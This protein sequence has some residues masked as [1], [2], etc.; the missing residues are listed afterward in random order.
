MEVAIEEEAVGEED[1][2]YEAIAVEMEEE[3]VATFAVFAPT[4]SAMARR[5]KSTDASPVERS[6]ALLE[7]SSVSTEAVGP[8]PEPAVPSRVRAKGGKRGVGLFSGGSQPITGH[9]REGS[10]YF[11]WREGVCLL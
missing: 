10:V 11:G 1:A 9:K 2:G 7:A 4:A 8:P 6:A 3:H 5:T